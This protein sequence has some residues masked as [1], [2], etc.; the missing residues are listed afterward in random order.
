M[1]WVAIHRGGWS[2][3]ITE[4]YDDPI[5]G[6]VS[7]YGPHC[8]ENA[9]AIADA[10]NIIGYLEI[11][12]EDEEEERLFRGDPSAVISI[13]LYTAGAIIIILGIL[14]WQLFF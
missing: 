3:V 13:F 14:F 4:N 5:L 1:K 8:E 10:L 11:K 12:D 2:S 9:E 6:I 7:C